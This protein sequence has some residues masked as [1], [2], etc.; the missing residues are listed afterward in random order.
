MNKEIKKIAEEIKDEIVAL[1]RKIHMNPELGYEE[2]ETSKLVSEKLKEYGIETKT[3]IAKLGVIG[4]IRGT[5][6]DGPTIGIRADMDALP[7]QEENDVPYKSKV[8]GKMH[9]CGHDAHTAILLG[10]GKILV[11]LKNKIKGNVKLFFQPAEEG[12]GGAKPMVEEGALKDPE[13]SAVIALHVD[14]DVEINMIEIKDGSFTASSDE[15]WI[16]I[17]GKGGHAALP[18]ETIDPII[19]GSYIVNAIQTIAS[20]NTNPVHSI[21]VTVGT[22]HAGTIYNIIPDT[23]HLTGTIRA[24]TPQDR[25]ETYNH[26]QRIVK[27]AQE[28]FGGEITIGIRLGYSP[29]MNDSDLNAILKE[30]ASEII[31]EDNIKIAEFP[32]MGAEDFFDFSDNNR[33]PVSMFWLG[34]GNEKKGIIYP[35][36]N[37]RFDIDEDAIPI[38][39][40]ILA[41]TALRYLE[42]YN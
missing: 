25:E 36:H 1:R 28:T 37:P 7:L 18:H 5:A 27:G 34:V 41:L 26:L 32:S 20:R 4:I 17:K 22:F 30:A 33:I 16:D 19:V 8:D 2:F 31:G 23:A 39:C 21:V 3:N 6:G 38:G 15:F 11:K 13:V 40:S 29:G 12:K 35:G 24:L 42:K 14:E 10:V 9:A